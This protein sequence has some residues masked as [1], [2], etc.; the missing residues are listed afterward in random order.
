MLN[1]ACQS[2]PSGKRAEEPSHSKLDDLIAEDPA[3]ATLNK[4]DASEESSKPVPSIPTAPKG[5]TTAAAAGGGD[6]LAQE[7][8]KLNIGKEQTD[9][10]GT[11]TAAV[12]LS[13]PLYCKYRPWKRKH[14][15]LGVCPV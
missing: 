6:A 2:V 11:S 15:F 10:V 14:A 8:E 12:F 13:P 5:E 9:E 3:F 1:K 7:L 4:E